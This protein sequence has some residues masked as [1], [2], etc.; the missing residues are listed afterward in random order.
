[1]YSGKLAGD[2]LSNGFSGNS[3]VTIKDVA[4]RVEG[5][6]FETRNI[7]LDFWDLN[8]DPKKCVLLACLYYM[9]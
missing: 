7:L 4:P 9:K 5:V 3:L 8:P 1:M 2:A 6:R